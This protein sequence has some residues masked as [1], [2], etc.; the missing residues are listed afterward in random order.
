MTP[1]SSGKST[2]AHEEVHDFTLHG[3][4]W[5]NEPDNP[6]STVTDMQGS[7]LAEYFNYEI[8]SGVPRKA[9]QVRQGHP[10][11]GRRRHRQRRCRPWSSTA[12]ASPV[13]TCTARARWTT[14]GS[15]CGASSA[16]RNQAMPGLVPLPDRAKPRHGQPVAGAQA[17]AAR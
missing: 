17:R 9:D 2:G 11:G 13:T 14:S 8:Q 15:G 3:H 12:P 16:P 6:Q 7:A 5:L 10:R 4:R 1:W